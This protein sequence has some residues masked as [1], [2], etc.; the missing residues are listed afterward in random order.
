M[1]AYRSE[2][3][4]IRNRASG[5]TIRDRSSL[6]AVGEKARRLGVPSLIILSGYV[7]STVRLNRC[8]LV[9]FATIKQRDSTGRIRSTSSVMS[10]MSIEKQVAKH[11]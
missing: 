2:T 10:L 7:N 8:A 1:L 9:L 11:V 4:V 5:W 3:G 6:I